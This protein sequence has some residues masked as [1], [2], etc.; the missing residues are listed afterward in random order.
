M[1]GVHL[2]ESLNLSKFIRIYSRRPIYN[3]NYFGHSERR[4]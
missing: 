2:F 1:A 3:V 4:F